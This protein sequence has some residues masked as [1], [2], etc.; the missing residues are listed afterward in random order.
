VAATNM[1]P[2]AHYI[3]WGSVELREPVSL[4]PRLFA[5]LATKPRPCSAELARIL[6][7]FASPPEIAPEKA[8]ADNRRQVGALWAEHF[9]FKSVEQ[10]QC[11]DLQSALRFSKYAIQTLPNEDDPITLYFHIFQEC[12]RRAIEAFTHTFAGVGLLVL[13]V[14]HRDG[15]PLAE[16]SCRSFSDSAREIANLIVVGDETLPEDVFYFDS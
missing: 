16:R 1:N 8:R 6:E 15:V 9:M 4:I 7:T 10:Y 3:H 14:S 11:S 13:H 5:K 2:L 12:S